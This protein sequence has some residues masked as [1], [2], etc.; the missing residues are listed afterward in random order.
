MGHCTELPII[1]VAIMDHSDYGKWCCH[2]EAPAF[3][4]FSGCKCLPFLP[5]LR[6]SPLSMLLILLPWYCTTNFAGST[7]PTGCFSSWQW[8]FTSVWTAVH[9]RTCRTTVV[10]PPVSTLGSTCVPPTVNCLQYLATG[11][12]LTA[13]GPFQLPAPTVWNSPG[14]HPKPDHQCRLFQTFA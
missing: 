1:A 12:T 14:F 5:S 8:L 7:S 2:A 6:S 9:R 4:F 11:S 13:V 3:H 10:W